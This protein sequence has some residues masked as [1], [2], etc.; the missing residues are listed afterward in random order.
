M[1]ERKVDDLT[2]EVAERDFHHEIVRIADCGELEKE[3]A[4]LGIFGNFVAVLPPFELHRHKAI[5]DALASH[6]PDRADREMRL[7][8]TSNRQQLLKAAT[9]LV[10]DETTLEG[11]Q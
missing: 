8:C 10:A 2:R 11:D 3:M 1:I 5:V 4:R 6:D 7:H 9:A